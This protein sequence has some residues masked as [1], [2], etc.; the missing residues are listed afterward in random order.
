[1]VNCSDSSRNDSSGFD[2][3][4]LSRSDNPSMCLGNILFN[5][6]NFLAWNYSFKMVLGAKLKLGFIDVS[7]LKLGDNS[8]KLI[9]WIRCYYMVQYW[10]L[11]SINSVLSQYF[12]YV[13]SSLELWNEIVEQYDQSNNPLVYQLQE[14]ICNLK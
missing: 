12:L 14:E 5:G 8:P 13:Q 3:L 4:F 1:M 10:I 7:I 2:P 6:S 9:Q 11:N